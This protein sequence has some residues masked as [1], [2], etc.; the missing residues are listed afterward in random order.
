MI[1]KT[2]INTTL[3][4]A[5]TISTLNGASANTTVDPAPAKDVEVCVPGEC[6]FGLLN[7]MQ[8]SESHG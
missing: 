8:V 4:P 1:I 7:D 6:D 3:A 2:V 5:V